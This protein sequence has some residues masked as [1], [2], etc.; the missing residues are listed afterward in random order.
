[1]SSRRATISGSRSG[2]L[3]LA[4]GRAAR[5]FVGFTKANPFS[6]PYELQAAFRDARSIGLGS[7]VRIAGVEVGR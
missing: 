7:P 4:A 6:I 3:A 2:L 5:A 1:M